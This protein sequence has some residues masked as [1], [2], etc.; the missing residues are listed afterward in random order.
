MCPQFRATVFTAMLPLVTANLD[1]AFHRELLDGLGVGQMD[2]MVQMLAR[3]GI[4][5]ESG[6]DYALNVGF[7]N[8]GLTV[9]GDPF[10][11]FELLGLFGGL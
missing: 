9:N 1:L 5:R 11:P 6:D 8:G 10:E 2:G 3:E 4:L 7:A